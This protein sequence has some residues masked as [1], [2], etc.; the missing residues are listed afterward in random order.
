MHFQG[1]QVSREMYEG[2]ELYPRHASRADSDAGQLLFPLDYHAGGGKKAAGD[3]KPFFLYSGL[4][5]VSQ[6]KIS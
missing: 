2:G 1:E 3:E 5:Q 6:S 4:C